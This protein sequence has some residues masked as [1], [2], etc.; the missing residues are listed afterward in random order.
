MR[1]EVKKICLHCYA[2]FTFLAGSKKEFT[3]RKFCSYEC[4]GNYYAKKFSEERVGE[5]NPMFGKKPWN[6][7]KSIDRKE[8][9]AKREYRKRKHG[10]DGVITSGKSGSRRK[11]YLV[12]HKDGKYKMLHRIIM[13]NEIGRKLRDD[14]VV[15][16]IDGNG[17]NNVIGNLQIMTKS[18]HLRHHECQKNLPKKG[19]GGL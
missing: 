5:G 11:K 13:E 19:G 7:G 17:L 16:H 9:T 1:K 15:H 12:L 2:E 6:Y 3:M 4:N 8:R 18:E 10:F 14:E